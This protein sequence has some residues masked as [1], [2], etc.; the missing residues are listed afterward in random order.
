MAG[1]K[2]SSGSSGSKDS[3]DI[4]L[5]EEAFAA[6]NAGDVATLRH[7]IAPDAVHR[8]PGSSAVSGDV[9]GREGILERFAEIAKETDGTY[10]AMPQLML[11]DGQGHVVTVVQAKGTRQGRTLDTT[12]TI[13]FT[14]VD[15]KVEEALLCSADLDGENAF[16][17]GTEL[18]AHG[19]AEVVRRGYEAFSAGDGKALSE[20]FER[21][22]THYVGGDSMF[23][24]TYRGADDVLA[25][26]GR[27]AEETDGSFAVELEK[28]TEDG[29]GHVVTVH[30]VTARRAGKDLDQRNALMF[31]LHDGKVSELHDHAEH[32]AAQDEFWAPT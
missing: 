1:T 18:P 22:V 14:I 24:G 30:H 3:K 27:L 13:T 23:T 7:I 26:Y 20:L 29:R 25:F 6:F 28:V 21:D 10:S 11:E 12:N 31:Q 32:L 5:I 9:K 2:G 4:A 17:G 15:G 19:D 8:A 16:W